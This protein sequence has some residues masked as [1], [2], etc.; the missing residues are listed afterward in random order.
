[1]L[2]GSAAL[3]L[4]R[5]QNA[6]LAAAGV[7]FGA[8]W[9]RGESSGGRALLAA[10]SAIGLAAFANTVND[11]FDVDIDRVAHPERPLPS[12]AMST[13]EARRIAA[14]AA[15]MGLASALAARPEL[16]ALSL[17]VLLIMLEYSRWIKRHGLAGNLVVAVLASLPFLYGAWSAGRPS[18]ALPLLLLATPLHLAREVAKDLEDVEGD[19]LRRRTLPLA[20]GFGVARGVLAAALLAFLAALAPF[21][22]PRPLFAALVAPAVLLCVL[23]ARRSF[24]GRRGGPLLLKSA[25]VWSM[26]ALLLSGR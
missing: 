4:V 16:G 18:A 3:Q 9:A 20:A 6:L 8:W 19:L 25:M 15:V 10:A 2:W 11:L 14:V 22:A 24:D 13:A 1:M 26:G 7:L 12:G 23:A 17:A 21:V 5:W